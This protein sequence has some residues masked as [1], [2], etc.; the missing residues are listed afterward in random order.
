MF[1]LKTF[2]QFLKRRFWLELGSGGLDMMSHFLNL[3]LQ[4][5]INL[6]QKVKL[7]KIGITSLLVEVACI[8][9]PILNAESFHLKSSLQEKTNFTV[10]TLIKK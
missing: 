2:V 5:W 8:E 9:R 3:F 6:Q 7:G 10:V 4:T 1:I